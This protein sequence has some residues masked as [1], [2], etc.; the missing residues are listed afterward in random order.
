MD[1]DVTQE[2]VKR[3]NPLPLLSKIKD[4]LPFSTLSEIAFSTNCMNKLHEFNHF[5]KNGNLPY[6]GYASKERQD[7]LQIFKKRFASKKSELLNWAGFKKTIKREH[8]N[9]QEF[10]LPLENWTREIAFKINPELEIGYNETKNNKQEHFA[11]LQYLKSY[12]KEIFADYYF[13]RRDEKIYQF[14]KNF[15]GMDNN[16]LN[17][18]FNRIKNSFGEE[19]LNKIISSFR[20]LK[21][22][23]RSIYVSLDGK[24]RGIIR[25]N[26]EFI[27]GNLFESGFPRIMENDADLFLLKEN[28]ESIRKHLSPANVKNLD[29]FLGNF[30]TF[31]RYLNS[32]ANGLS[33]AQ[34]L[35]YSY[36]YLDKFSSGKKKFFNVYG[37]LVDEL[38]DKITLG[39]RGLAEEIKHKNLK[40]LDNIGDYIFVSGNGDLDSAVKIRDLEKF[41]VE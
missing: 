2:I 30:E 33:N 34:D 6:Y 39:Y 13:V 24:D 29:S 5:K 35:I 28:S 41:F 38:T 8:E 19:K 36:I 16:V 3:I 27:Q 7:K 21:N 14:T 22:H 9:V 31:E 1:L 18:N 20:Y 17:E 37:V 25:P 15:L 4:I 11:F 12:M 23:F 32:N 10:Y 40:Y 26:Q